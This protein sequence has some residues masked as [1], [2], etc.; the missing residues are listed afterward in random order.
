M[1]T[2]TITI[3]APIIFFGALIIF[4]IIFVP[5]TFRKSQRKIK[6]ARNLLPN[7]AK[8]TGLKPK[9]NGAYGNYKGYNLDLTASMSINYPMVASAIMGNNIGKLHSP[10]T[11]P[12]S[13]QVT[14]TAN[15]NF[16][17]TAFFQSMSWWRTNQ[18]IMDLIKQREPNI[19]KLDLENPELKKI[20]VYGEDQAFASKILNHPNFVNA[21]KD[22]L[23]PDIR[24]SGETITLT[25]DNNY[26]LIA[27]TYGKNLETVQFFQ[28]ML[29][30]CVTT[31]NIASM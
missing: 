9:S 3:L 16:P 13:Y 6:E 11:M 14:L 20:D 8:A 21:I 7:L 24:I 25:L 17:R 2:S 1:G 12:P 27:S 31:A 10:R 19:P 29:D 26:L 28:E 5:R 15:Q 22:W 4:A 30:I 23:Y 18:K